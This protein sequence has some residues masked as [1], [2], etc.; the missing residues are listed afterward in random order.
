MEL[1]W[2]EICSGLRNVVRT[3]RSVVHSARRTIVGITVRT[4]DGATGGARVG[5]L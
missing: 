3:S 2:G 5:R 4:I 1:F